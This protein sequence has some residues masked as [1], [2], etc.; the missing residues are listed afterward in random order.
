MVRM[1]TESIK[2]LGMNSRRNE[3]HF[4]DYNMILFLRGRTKGRSQELVQSNMERGD[5]P[6]HG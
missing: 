3:K 2:V 6:L 5:V 4:Q 1:L